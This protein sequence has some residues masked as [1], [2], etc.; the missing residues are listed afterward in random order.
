MRDA[1]I[2]IL[3][4]MHS[5]VLGTKSGTIQI[6]SFQR[7]NALTSARWTQ[8]QHDPARRTIMF[9]LELVIREF[10]YL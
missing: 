3:E 9:T 10:V 1:T 6:D 4:V 7:F 8:S 2:A 5:H